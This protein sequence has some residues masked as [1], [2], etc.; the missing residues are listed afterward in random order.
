MLELGKESYTL[1]DIEGIRSTM[2]Q[3]YTLLGQSTEKVENMD[4]F[5]PYFLEAVDP[6]CKEIH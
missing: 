3:Y 4:V 2:I 5:I 1:E 6:V